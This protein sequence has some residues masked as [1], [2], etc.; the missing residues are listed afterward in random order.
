MQLG[1]DID[2]ATNSPSIVSL[3][4]TFPTSTHD[5]VSDQL[6]LCPPLCNSVELCRFKLCKEKLSSATATTLGITQ[7]DFVFELS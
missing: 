5:Q 7:L 1:E 2:N 3:T 4:L 6:W